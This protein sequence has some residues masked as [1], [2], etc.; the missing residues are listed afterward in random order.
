MKRG[1]KSQ[2]Q[3]HNRHTRERHTHTYTL[4]H[5]LLPQMRGC[6]R[7]KNHV[8]TARGR[9]LRGGNLTIPVSL[10]VAATLAARISTC[11]RANLPFFESG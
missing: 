5:K 10:G 7:K 9:G 4:F 1:E 6:V 3:T 11:K 2:V 8:E